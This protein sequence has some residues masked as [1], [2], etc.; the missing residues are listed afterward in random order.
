MDMYSTFKNAFTLLCS[1]I[2]LLLIYQLVVTFV[3]EKPTTTAKLEKNLEKSDLPEVVVCM[4][5]G[6]DSLAL[7]RVGYHAST[8]FEGALQP[9]SSLFVGWN[10][11]SSENKSSHEILEEALLLPKDEGLVLEA[12]YT[13][14]FKDYE[15]AVVTF[16]TLGNSNGR[17]LFINPSLNKTN[18]YS[19]WIK[20]NNSFIDQFNSRLEPNRSSYKLILLGDYN[21]DLNKYDNYKND[22]KMCPVN[23]H[24]AKI[25]LVQLE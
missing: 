17:C 4:Q 14:D 20:F 9:N 6:L 5:P 11:N 15:K 8:Y 23:L 19:L 2:T 10:G 7:K 24:Y 3:V 1:A 12:L 13:D 18:P 25:F 16:R 21:I 22:F